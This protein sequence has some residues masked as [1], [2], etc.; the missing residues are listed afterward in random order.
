MKK[1][2]PKRIITEEEKIN[3]NEKVTCDKCGKDIVRAYIEKHVLWVHDGVRP[4]QC[5]LCDKAFIKKCVLKRH[6]QSFH[7]KQKNHICDLCGK[8]FSMFQH[9]KI[10]RESQHEG[11]TPKVTCKLCNKSFTRAGYL[12]KHMKIIHEGDRTFYK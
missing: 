4:F 8:A 7:E 10:H 5:K 6:V 12:R 11:K 2:R 3:K 9:L 1:G